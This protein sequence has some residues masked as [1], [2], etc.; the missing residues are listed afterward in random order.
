MA[1]EESRLVGWQ[2]AIFVQIVGKLGGNNLLNNLGQKRD[3]SYGPKVSWLIYIK[4]LSFNYRN[5]N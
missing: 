3:I 1:L 2:K 4:S 5:K